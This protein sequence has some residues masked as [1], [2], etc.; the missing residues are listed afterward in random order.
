[1]TPRYFVRI[2]FHL[3]WICVELLTLSHFVLSFPLETIVSSVHVTAA[4]TIRRS[5]SYTPRTTFTQF[6][7]T[8]IVGFRTNTLCILSITWV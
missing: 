3:R 2:F 4:F 1:M 6:Q 5:V 7:A 8:F